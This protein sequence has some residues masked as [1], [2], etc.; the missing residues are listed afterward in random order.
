M[1]RNSH[2]NNHTTLTIK[3]TVSKATDNKAT[4]NKAMVSKVTASKVTASKTIV[5]TCR[6]ALKTI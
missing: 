1:R 2:S 6:N 3:V 5:V 4:V